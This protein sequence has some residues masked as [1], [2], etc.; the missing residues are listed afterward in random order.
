MPAI[1]RSLSIDDC[2]YILI[3]GEVKVTI[4]HGTMQRDLGLYSK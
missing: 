1:D 4:G 2:R 3:S